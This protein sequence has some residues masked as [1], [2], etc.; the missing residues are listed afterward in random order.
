[1]ARNY[2]GMPAAVRD[3]ANANDDNDNDNDDQIQYA[4]VW[5]LYQTHLQHLVSVYDERDLPTL[6]NEY[7]VDGALEHLAQLVD[8]RQGTLV[9]HA[10]TP[11]HYQGFV[12]TGNTCY[13]DSTLFALF[14]FHSPFD[15]LL[16]KPI[17]RPEVKELQTTLRF[18]TNQLR[19]GALITPIVINKLRMDLYHAGWIHQSIPGSAATTTQED[20]SEFF[21][22]LLNVL[23]APYLSMMQHVVYDGCASI[24]DEN[25][26]KSFRERILS[27]AI[28]LSANENPKVLTVEDLLYSYFFD[29]KITVLRERDTQGC[30]R[31]TVEAWQASHIIPIEGGN[32][33]LII[34]ML[35][36]RYDVYGR[37]IGKSTGNVN[38][39]SAV[40]GH[41]HSLPRIDSVM[42]RR[43]DYTLVLRAAVCHH[44]DSLASGH[45]IAFTTLNGE[46]WLLFDD[47]RTPRVVK[48]CDLK[49]ITAAFEHMSTSAYLLLYE[50]LSDT[51]DEALPKQQQVQMV[52]DMTTAQNLQSQEFERVATMGPRIPSHKDAKNCVI[53]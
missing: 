10:T 43:M 45:Y 37:R 19:L 52:D 16:L 30:T 50:M 20:A 18:I 6:I 35:L 29:N 34:P 22:F 11:V 49:S 28:P 23:E 31:M 27:L 2:P 15:W 44:G 47:M 7:S 4:R 14:L 40:A 21:L 13:L 41:Q 38:G 9:K 5:S 12:N 39:T 8:A 48:F 53:M 46:E 33:N 1:M 42:P 51:E 36:K 25:D 3:R 17:L 26:Q 24:T 32:S